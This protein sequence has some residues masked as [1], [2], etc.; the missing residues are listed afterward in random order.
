MGNFKVIPKEV[1]EQI[2]SRIKNDG[3]SI[4]QAAEEHGIS[5]RTIYGWLKKQSI[6]SVSFMEYAHLRKQNKQLMEL[7]GRLSLEIEKMKVLKKG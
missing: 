3:V 6:S 5:N 2:L 7:A 1:L 4:K